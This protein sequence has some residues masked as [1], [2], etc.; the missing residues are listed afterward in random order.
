MNNSLEIVSDGDFSL[1]ALAEGM[2]YRG[3]DVQI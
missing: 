3:F 2:K 1:F